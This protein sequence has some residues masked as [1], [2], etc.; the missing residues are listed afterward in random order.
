MQKELRTLGVHNIHNSCTCISITITIQQY[1]QTETKTLEYITCIPTYCAG[2]LSG[3]YK[4]KP[5]K[6][7]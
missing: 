3:G 2:R 5:G 4:I 1:M 7:Q 6:E